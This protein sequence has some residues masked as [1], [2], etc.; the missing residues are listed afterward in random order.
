MKAA[1]AEGAFSSH[2]AMLRSSG[3]FSSAI[4]PFLP[5]YSL[6]YPTAILY[7]H[8]HTKIQIHARKRFQPHNAIGFVRNKFDNSI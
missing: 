3:T 6:P 5:S 1:A 8:T 7:I 4:K 2:L